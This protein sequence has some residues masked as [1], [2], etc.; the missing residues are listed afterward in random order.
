MLEGM[1][2]C[3]KKFLMDLSK[4]IEIKSGFEL[5]YNGFY[6]LKINLVVCVIL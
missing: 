1:Y 2:F 4:K 6:F 5:L 3:K